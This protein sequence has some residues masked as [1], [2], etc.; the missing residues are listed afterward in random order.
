MTS[1]PKVRAGRGRASRLALAGGLAALS[2][3]RC[4]L[5]PAFAAGVAL[6]ALGNHPS[7][8][9]TDVMPIEAAGSSTL[10]NISMAQ[11]A[12]Y[13][14]SGGSGGSGG[15]GSG[16]TPG[17]SPGQLQFN[18]AG[19]FGG[20]TLAGDC[21]FSEPAITCT[22]TNGAPFARSATI[23]TTDGAN[24]TSGIIPTY[25][26][27]TGVPSVT[28]YLR[29]DQTWAVISDLCSSDPFPIGATDIWT[30]AGVPTSSAYPDGTLYLR[31]DYG[32]VYRY[33]SVS[34]ATPALVQ[35]AVAA[36]G[37]SSNTTVTLGTA[38]TLGNYLIAVGFGPGGSYTVPTLAT[39]WVMISTA[40]DGAAG[41]GVSRISAYRVVQ[42]GDGATVTPFSA[43]T[44]S[45]AVFEVS[46]LS[47]SWGA[48]FQ[49]EQTCIGNF[50][51]AC[52]ALSASNTTTNTLALGV[53]AISINSGTCCT[54]P[55]A[56]NGMTG[57]Q[58]GA[59]SA[60]SVVVANSE[61]LASSAGSVSI[62]YTAT[63]TVSGGISGDLLLLQPGA[64]EDSGWQPL[65]A[66]RTI[67]AQG[68]TI[69]LD[70]L[71][72]NFA[73][74]LIATSD[75]AGHITVSAT[76][77]ATTVGT[78]PTSPTTGLSA[79]VTDATSC[80]F[81]TTVS[82]GGSTRCPVIWNGSAWVAG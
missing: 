76:V 31:T 41:N 19:A 11:L 37:G 46:G 74:G 16:G 5:S 45:L 63:G 29:G 33:R 71:Q 20:F 26:L 65:S 24:I 80:T 1:I 69:E 3:A 47:T 49:T 44:Y 79:V 7:P 56:L 77:G 61:F 12:A 28:T 22:K 38:P 58:V 50:G 34:A 57:T 23:D 13:F 70:P 15:G 18:S 48:S 2:L 6:T 68:T 25:V 73:A 27:G 4:G 17:G 81:N 60:P 66:L 40:N 14:G 21:A 8:S 67:Q 78:L 35:Q 82:G 59:Y 39:G 42:P 9:S 52:F 10:Q 32:D 30:A 54:G 36:T 64:A 43:S 62:S 75:T 51:G 53:Y 55:G 72:V